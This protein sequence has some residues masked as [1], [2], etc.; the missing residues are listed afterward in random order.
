MKVLKGILATIAVLIALLCGVIILCAFHPELSEK[1]GA[2]MPKEKE[3]ETEAEMEAPSSDAYDTYELPAPEIDEEQLN[4][5]VEMDEQTEDI[6]VLIPDYPSLQYG[7]TTKRKKGTNGYEIPAEENVKIP[8][9]V[10]GKS[11][12]VPIS[13]KS[14]ELKTD[15]EAPGFGET[16]DGLTFDS[17]FYPYYHM[18]DDKGK[19]VYRQIYVNANA[20]KSTFDT[21]EKIPVEEI[22][23]VVEAVY[24]DHPELFWLE[25]AFTCK[26]D[27]DKNAVRL[28]LEFNETA[29]NLQ[30]SWQKFDQSAGEILA[31]A[32]GF[33]DTFEKEKRVHD[34]LIEQISYNKAAPMNQSAYSALVNG[35][36]VCAGYARAMQY[37][38]QKMGIPCYYCTG[39]AGEDHAWNILALDDGYYNVDVTW[40]DTPGGEYNFFNKSDLDFANNHVRKSLSVNLPPCN[41]QKYRNL[42]RSTGGSGAGEALPSLADVGFKDSDVKKMVQ[43]YFDD[44]YNTMVDTGRGSYVFQNVI[45]GDALFRD[46]YQAYQ[47]DLYK[48]AY[49]DRAMNALGAT[50][51][52]MELSAEPLQDGKYLI[53]HNVSMY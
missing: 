37:L 2:I 35:E 29:E 47:T 10:T 4:L 50:K 53:T 14:E 23:D 32:Q 20:Q 36:T 11:G 25:T 43:E 13:E 1:I 40:D 48:N 30:D 24:N 45:E 16:G 12:Y 33:S 18:L 39:Y 21:L 42:V 46:W 52:H 5:S 41:G 44:C 31:Q 26:Y 27:K 19:H 8:S 38:M 6:Q 15:E 49:A 51:C 3:Q 7:D 22:R 9:S 28:I 17:L 34:L